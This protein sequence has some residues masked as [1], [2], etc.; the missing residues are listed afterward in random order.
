MKK[1]IIGSSMFMTGIISAVILLAGTMAN[2][3]DSM[4]IS[5]LAV[6]MQI[7]AKYGLTPFLYVAVGVAVVGAAVAIWGLLEKESN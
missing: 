3:Y 2:E 4:N 6:A 1:V 7:L 5:P